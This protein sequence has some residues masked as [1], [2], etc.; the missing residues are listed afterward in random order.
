MLSELQM[1]LLQKKKN[2]IT[3]TMY[4]RFHIDIIHV[5]KKWSKIRKTT[6]K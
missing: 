4:G 3:Y 6:E 2:K 5:G 1:N